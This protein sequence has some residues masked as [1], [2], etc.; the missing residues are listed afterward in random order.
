MVASVPVSRF[1]PGSN[2]Y[3]ENQIWISEIIIISVILPDWS[4]N[5]SGF[6]DNNY[7][8]YLGP[9]WSSAAHP[10]STPGVVYV[11]VVSFLVQIMFSGNRSGYLR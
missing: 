9:E 3:S 2:L 8:N 7:L 5:R 1:V 11:A 10:T 6:Q 4:G